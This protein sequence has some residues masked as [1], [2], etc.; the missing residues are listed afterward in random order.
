MSS[1]KFTPGPWYAFGAA[2]TNENPS[3]YK[4]GTPL[5]VIACTGDDGHEEQAAEQVANA[6]LIAAAP[7]LYEALLNIEV[8]FRRDGENSLD[9]FERIASQFQKDTGYMRP[10]KSA[11]MVEEAPQYDENLRRK[12]WDEWVDDKLVDAR[13]AL[14]KARGE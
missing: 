1:T 11:P 5:N 4:P 8:L 13:S 6:R 9:T 10:G 7:E 14:K 2:V 3:M 12:K